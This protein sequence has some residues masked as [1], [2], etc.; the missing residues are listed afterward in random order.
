MEKELRATQFPDTTE[1]GD[2]AP[3]ARAARVAVRDANAPG[4]IVPGAAP[5]DFELTARRPRRVGSRTVLIVLDIVP[6]IDPL[7]NVPEHVKQ[8]KAIRLALADFMPSAAAI[9]L[10]PSDVVQVAVTAVRTPT[11]RRIF[12]LC[13]C[14]QPPPSPPAISRSFLPGNIDHWVVVAFLRK[15]RVRT[16]PSPTSNGAWDIFRKGKR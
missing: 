6:V 12:P 5:Q 3:E 8:S 16:E 11:A 7:P 4:I 10:V 9:P 15:S 1:P 14:R 2:V 13:L